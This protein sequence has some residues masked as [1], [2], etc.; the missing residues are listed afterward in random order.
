M[1]IRVARELH[2][3]YS[4]ALELPASELSIWQ[5]GFTEEYYIYHPEKRPQPEDKTVESNI[6]L[7]KTMLS[8]KKNK[9]IDKTSR[10]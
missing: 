2:M 1:C 6:E 4:A 8:S 5:Q 9:I 7:L 3:P 10:G